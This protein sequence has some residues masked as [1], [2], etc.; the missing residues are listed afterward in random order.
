MPLELLS[1]IFRHTVPQ[2]IRLDVHIIP[3]RSREVLKYPKFLFG[4][5]RLLTR[6]PIVFHINQASRK[7]AMQVY[8]LVT[9]GDVVTGVN[10]PPARSRCLLRMPI[11]Y[12]DP[13]FD[14]ISMCPYITGE[15]K[16]LARRNIDI[17]KALQV[18]GRSDK[19]PLS[20]VFPGITKDTLLDV[21]YEAAGLALGI[22]DIEGN[23]QISTG[24][25]HS[26]VLGWDCQG[27]FPHRRERWKFSVWKFRDLFHKEDWIIKYGHDRGSAVGHIEHGVGYVVNSS[28]NLV[29]DSERLKVSKKDFGSESASSQ[30]FRKRA[31]GRGR[32][33]PVRRDHFKRVYLSF[34]IN[35]Q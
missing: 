19:T 14:Y 31:W 29:T 34:T 8:K 23:K 27:G 5:A 22:P 35:T 20:V 33:K 26:D 32:R 17:W 9:L 6:L 25:R 4:S 1:N 10:V 2:L 28:G 11:I 16:Q 30:N 15:E 7:E 12:L 3:S 13:A 21:V 24:C 18:V